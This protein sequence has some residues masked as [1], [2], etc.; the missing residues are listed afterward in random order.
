M[1]I[2]PKV[3]EVDVQGAAER[4]P[5]ATKMHSRWQFRNRARTNVQV[6][7]QV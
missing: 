3:L 2:S 6:Y 7:V 1:D 5:A 4:P